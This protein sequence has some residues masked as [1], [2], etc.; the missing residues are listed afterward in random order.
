[1]HLH[2][3]HTILVDGL[4]WQD[5]FFPLLER[6]RERERERQARDRRR[7]PKLLQASFFFG[8]MH[9][10]ALIPFKAI[11]VTGVKPAPRRRS[12]RCSAEV[13]PPKATS[14]PKP[15]APKESEISSP[16][17]KVPDAAPAAAAA[18]AT[19]AE[20]VKER[21]PGPL[22][23]GGSLSGDQ[24]RG[25]DPAKKPVLQD[26]PKGMAGGEQGCTNAVTSNLG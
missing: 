16:E 6:E 22:Q 11:A 9:S 1:M 4:L 7:Q 19:S 2:A 8:P 14:Q 10:K 13:E 21:K 3:F 12:L 25:K 26:S 17:I 20:S 15:D 24:A 18:S 5:F 23:R